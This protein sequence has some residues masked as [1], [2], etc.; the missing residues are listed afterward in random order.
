[1]TS[2]DCTRSGSAPAGPPL[3][4]EQRDR[5]SRQ[6]AMPEVGVAGQRKLL[7]SS[8]LV[9]GLGGLG[10]PAAMYLAA[11]GIGRIGLADGDLVQRSNL[12]RQILHTTA[13]I[14]TLKVHSAAAKLHALNP[15]T[16]ITPHPQQVTAETLTSLL[17][18]YDYNFALDATDGINKEGGNFDTIGLPLRHTEAP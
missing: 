9:I 14:G 11:A 8:V 7:A 18:D 1:M 13:D 10:S 3:T 5:Y 15:H 2:D 4:A 6:I 17:T 12:N 16:I